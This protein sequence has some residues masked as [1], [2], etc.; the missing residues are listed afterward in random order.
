MK[1]DNY[2]RLRNTNVLVLIFNK[3]FN[4]LKRSK[5]LLGNLKFQKF[6]RHVLT[7]LPTANNTDNSIHRNTPEYLKIFILIGSMYNMVGS[8][9][10]TY[11]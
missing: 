8:V 6:C 11:D 1:Y 4:F 10:G 5:I 7:I 2:V 3:I 9:F